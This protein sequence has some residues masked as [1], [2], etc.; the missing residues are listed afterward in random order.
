MPTNDPDAKVDVSSSAVTTPAVSTP[1]LADAHLASFEKLKP[2]YLTM[3]EGELLPVTYS[4]TSAVA[5][6]LGLMA[7]LMTMREQAAKLPDYDASCFDRLPD[8]TRALAYAHTNTLAPAQG[9]RVDLVELGAA[10]VA[11]REKLT[12]EFNHLARYQLL[13]RQRLAGIKNLVG[14]KNVA[15]DLTALVKILREAWPT[16][17]GKTLLTPADLEH[18]QQLA[19][20]LLATVGE[21]DQSTSASAE[22]TAM[23]QRAF[24]LFTRTYDQVRRAVTFLLWDDPEQLEAVCPSLYAGRRSGKRAGKDETSDE[25]PGPDAGPVSPPAPVAGSGQG[26]EGGAVVATHI[27]GQPGGSPFLR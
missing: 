9:P 4:V 10:G 26:H 6:V 15:F 27:P 7:R 21:R 8:C 23:R 17:A 11:T 12:E 2:R 16:I 14:Y 5:M 22:A 1:L 18:A 25:G 24:T 13:D 3:A 20:Q 19:E